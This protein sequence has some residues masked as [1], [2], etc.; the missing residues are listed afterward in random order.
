MGLKLKLILFVTLSLSTG[1]IPSIYA[2]KKSN[3]EKSNQLLDY[4]SGRWHA[5][6]KGK[7]KA[8]DRKFTAQSTL[9]INVSKYSK[10]EMEKPR[11]HKHNVPHHLVTGILR[12]DLFPKRGSDSQCEFPEEINEPFTGIVLGDRIVFQIEIR[13]SNLYR[14]LVTKIVMGEIPLTNEIKKGKLK[15]NVSRLFPNWFGIHDSE[16]RKGSTIYTKSTNH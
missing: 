9:T 11:E 7:A 16:I 12:V 5:K 6:L 1:F 3:Q 15:L 14:N 4:V 10:Y 8:V 13:E 2:K